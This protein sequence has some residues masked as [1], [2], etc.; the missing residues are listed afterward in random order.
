MAS[1]EPG[2]LRLLCVSH[3]FESHRGG[4]EMVAGRLARSLADTDLSVTWAACDAS[5]PPNDLPV[6]ALHAWN[7]IERR[8]GLPF[9]LHGPGSLA[10]LFGA[11]R[12]SDAVLVHD[13]MYPI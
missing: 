3:Y 9:P 5:P 2:S 4:I 6:L 11:I 13:G 7:G 12:K 8:S 1:E 10:R